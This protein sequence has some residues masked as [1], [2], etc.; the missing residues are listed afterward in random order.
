MPL[1]DEAIRVLGEPGAPGAVGTARLQDGQYRDRA[2]EGMRA[3][4]A[5]H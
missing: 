5:T 2:V 3:P 4:D 1:T